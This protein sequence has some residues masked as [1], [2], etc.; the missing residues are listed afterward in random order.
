MRLL[1]WLVRGWHLHETVRNAG[2]ILL[3]EPFRLAYG[4]RG[5]KSLHH[6]KR[7]GDC[8][9]ATFFFCVLVAVKPKSRKDERPFAH[10]IIVLSWMAVL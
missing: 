8:R 3:P 1:D 2:L 5:S 7:S 9:G 4:V 10:D 6:G